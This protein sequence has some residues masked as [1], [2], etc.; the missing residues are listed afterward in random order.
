MSNTAEQNSGDHASTLADIKKLLKELSD[1]TERQQST[2][3][4]LSEKKNAVASS[5]RSPPV[6]PKSG[7]LTTRM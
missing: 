6:I 1:K 2:E 3:T 5:Q 7:K 4:S